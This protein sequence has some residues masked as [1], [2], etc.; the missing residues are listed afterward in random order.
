MKCGWLSGV[1]W[2]L[3]A[4]CTTLAF[5]LVGLVC[6][7]GIRWGREWGDPAFKYTSPCRE[8]NDISSSQ[9]LVIKNLPANAGDYKRYGFYPWVGKIQETI[10]DMGSIPG[11]GRSPGEGNGNSLQYSCL[12]NPMD[13]GAWW[14][15]VL[16]VAE[17]DTTEQLSMQLHTNPKW[18]VLPHQ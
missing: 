6:P 2:N 1:T 5:S 15:T 7:Q 11:L 9:P 3:P 12:E 10:R 4:G 17:S 18:S 13:R 8:L 14:A 16:G